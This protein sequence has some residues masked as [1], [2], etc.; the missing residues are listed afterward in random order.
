L[1]YDLGTYFI[2]IF[3]IYLEKLEKCRQERNKLM[4]C[5]TIA[6]TSL[7]KKKNIYTKKE[8][9]MYRNNIASNMRRTKSIQNKLNEDQK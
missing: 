4:N 3:L 5:D 1:K 9:T 7:R 8:M 2:I 6:G